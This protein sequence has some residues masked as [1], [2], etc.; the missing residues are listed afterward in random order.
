[1]GDIGTDEGRRRQAEDTIGADRNAAEVE[2]QARAIA[3]HLGMDEEAWR[4]QVP[5]LI[6]AEEGR[7]KSVWLKM[8]SP[9]RRKGF[10][11]YMASR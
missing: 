9:E 5:I 7:L 1:M 8:H 2:Q 10:A 6:A 3:R 4:E 11:D